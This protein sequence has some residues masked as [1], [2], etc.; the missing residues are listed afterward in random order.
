LPYFPIL[1]N[2]YVLDEMKY[3]LTKSDLKQDLDHE[4]ERSIQFFLEKLKWWCFDKKIF[5]KKSQRVDNQV[6][7]WNQL[8]PV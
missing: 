2:I 7:T 1:K 8:E 4:L 6:L 3:A 5:K